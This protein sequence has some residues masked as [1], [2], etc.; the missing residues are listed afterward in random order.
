MEQQFTREPLSERLKDYENNSDFKF[1][2]VEPQ[3]VAGLEISPK[4]QNYQESAIEIYQDTTLHDKYI[5]TD[6]DDIDYNFLKLQYEFLKTLTPE[7][8][9]CLKLY[10][11]HGYPAFRFFHINKDNIDLVTAGYTEEGGYFDDQTNIKDGI[12]KDINNI[13]KKFDFDFDYASGTTKD[14]MTKENVYF[15][16]SSY[17][18]TIINVF[19]RAPKTQRPIR[20][21]RGVKATLD[22]KLED[23]SG[24][25]S[26]SYDSNVASLESFFRYVPF[27]N[28]KN[29]CLLEIQVPLGIPAIWISPISNNRYKPAGLMGSATDEDE[30]EIVLYCDNN[31]KTSYSGPV[32]KSKLLF[33][34]VSSASQQNVYN[35][36]L[37]VK[38]PFQPIIP[39]STDYDTVKSLQTPAPAPAPAPEPVLNTSV[40]PKK[41]IISSLKSIFKKKGGNLRK[42]SKKIKNKKRTLRKRKSNRK[43][44]RK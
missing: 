35:V 1:N 5:Y 25:I 37:E 29:C 13:F 28:D 2:F 36:T 15:L 21:F 27:E 23:F 19:N 43:T 8:L 26:T 6:K 38:S 18:G 31:V 16:I 30:H 14:S 17:Y 20:L 39:P 34:K 41:G 42:T 44:H 10:S 12:L 4:F 40:Q 11:E 24:V 9:G 32:K 3:F 33:G 22:Q 7:E